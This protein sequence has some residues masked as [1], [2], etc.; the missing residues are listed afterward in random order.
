LDTDI[1]QALSVDDYFLADYVQAGQRTVNFYVAFYASQSGGE[2]THSPRTCMPGGG[3]EITQIDRATVSAGP[4]SL[5]VNRVIIQKGEQRQLV[6]YW[7][8]QRDRLLTNEFAVKWYIF[9]D[10]ITRD[11]SDGAL[12]RLVTPIYGNENVA[13]ADGRLQAFLAL[14][15]PQIRRFV[16]D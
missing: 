3:W 6:Y 11:R 4:E 2:S 7:F 9:R 15:E 8:K 14:S 10:G 1:V 12:I 13:T 5:P 16:P